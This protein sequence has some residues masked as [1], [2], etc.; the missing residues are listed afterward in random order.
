VVGIR[1]ELHGLVRGNRRLYPLDGAGYDPE[2]YLSVGKGNKF[3]VIPVSR[4]VVIQFVFW[5]L[6]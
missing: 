2:A 6:Y 1:G 3:Q 4:T 5:S